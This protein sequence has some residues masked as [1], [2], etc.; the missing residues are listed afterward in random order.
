MSS[1]TLGA[2]GFA[3]AAIMKMPGK[4][5]RHPVDTVRV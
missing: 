5:P 4:P 1:C 3:K 2:S